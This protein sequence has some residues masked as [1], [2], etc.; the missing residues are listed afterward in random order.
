MS[1]LV[2]ELLGTDA[3]H[4][5]IARD[6]EKAQAIGV[7][8]V[9]CFIIDERFMVAGAEKPETLAAAIKHAYE[10]KTG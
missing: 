4:E 5:K 8:G 7:T 2:A 6:L 10:T 3:D 9:P 1:D